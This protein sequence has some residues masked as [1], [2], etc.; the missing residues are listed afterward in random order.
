MESYYNKYE[1]LYEIPYSLRK[2]Q[3]LKEIKPDIF[4]L[5][6]KLLEI[7]FEEIHLFWIAKLYFVLTLDKSWEIKENWVLLENV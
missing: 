6:L 5:V 7:S 3:T 2:C 4:F 1:Q